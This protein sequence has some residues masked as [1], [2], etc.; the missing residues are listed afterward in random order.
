[1]FK[2]EVYI[3]NICF[4]VRHY[5][6]IALVVNTACTVITSK[7]AYVIPYLNFKGKSNTITV[8]KYNALPITAY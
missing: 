7:V 3:K 8:I 6:L 4:I 1:V 2:R 5:I